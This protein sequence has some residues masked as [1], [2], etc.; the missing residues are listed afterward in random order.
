V[1]GPQALPPKLVYWAAQLGSFTHCF[2]V[3]STGS[4]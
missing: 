1:A 2:T 3:H 4:D